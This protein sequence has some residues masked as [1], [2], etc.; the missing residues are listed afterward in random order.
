MTMDASG[1][2]SVSVGPLEPDLYEYHFTIDGTDNL[3]QRIRS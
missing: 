1:L 2:W 3:D